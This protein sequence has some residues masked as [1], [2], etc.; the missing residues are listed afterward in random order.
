MKPL[1]Y[2]FHL[3]RTYP[4]C[5]FN[6]FFAFLVSRWITKCVWTFVAWRKVI[7]S[8]TSAAKSWT[9]WDTLWC[10][11]E[12][13][14]NRF[15]PQDGSTKNHVSFPE[16]QQNGS[17][18]QFAN[19]TDTDTNNHQPL[20]QKIKRK[21]YHRHK[22]YRRLEIGNKWLHCY[23]SLAST[24]TDIRHRGVHKLRYVCL[25]F[26]SRFLCLQSQS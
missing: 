18:K 6:R 4:Q 26:Y 8:T 11:F 12:H 23:R 3:R 20:T 24:T 7:E 15:T 9:K 17:A 10:S 5:K 14:L 25:K 2:K 1:T 16:F 13:K 21:H 19:G 22:K